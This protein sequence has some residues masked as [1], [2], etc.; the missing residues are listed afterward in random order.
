MT[1]LRAELFHYKGL[2]EACKCANY[3]QERA[4]LLDSLASLR[5]AHGLQRTALDDA[6]A[7]LSFARAELAAARAEG[8]AAQREAAASASAAQAM[9]RRT[10]E[11]SRAAA[12]AK[13]EEGDDVETWRAEAARLRDR[14][15][16]VEAGAEASVTQCAALAAEKVRAAERRAEAAAAQLLLANA[17]AVEVA[18]VGAE[19]A[20]ERRQGEARAT[21]AAQEL[22]EAVRGVQEQ[23]AAELERRLA[24]AAAAFAEREA[25]LRVMHA[26][27]L[28]LAR[29]T[30]RAAAAAAEA[31]GGLSGGS[32]AFQPVALFRP[33]QHPRGLDAAEGDAAPLAPIIELV[34][35]KAQLRP[36]PLPVAPVPGAAE[37]PAGWAQLRPAQPRPAAPEASADE[38]PI[39]PSRPLISSLKSQLRSAPPREQEA[40]EPG[41]I[42]PSRAPIA[43]LKAQLRPAPPR[44]EPVE[45][46]A[47]P[48]APAA[49]VALRPAPPRSSS[50][51][52]ARAP[53]PLEQALQQRQA[54]RA[55]AAE[56]AAAAAAAAA[57]AATVTATAAAAT[58]AQPQRSSTPASAS[59]Q[60]PEESTTPPLPEDEDG[61]EGGSGGGGGGGAPAPPQT[62]ASFCEALRAAGLRSSQLAVFVDCTKSNITN[63]QVSFGGK[64]LHDTSDPSVPNPYQEVISFVV[65]ALAPFD[66]DGDVPVFGFGDQT[67]GD[68]KV[69]AFPP[70]RAGAGPLRAYTDGIATTKLAGPTCFAP[71]IR[72]AVDLY[73]AAKK[74][75]VLICVIIADG[76][77]TQPKETDKAVVEAN[78]YPISIVTVGVGDGP[79]ANME[80]M[81]HNINGQKWDSFRCAHCPPPPSHTHTVHP[82][83]NSSP[84]SHNV[85]VQ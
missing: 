36:P 76:Q 44:P 75:E 33:L 34:T 10:L 25:Q 32:S 81:C 68:K 13:E 69:F 72:R 71:A 18:T 16:S 61:A 82:R 39:A 23:H 47:P 24:D 57:V 79:W 48:R 26:E 12:A 22:A 1:S 40:E 56:E 41:A 8:A 15:R 21:R 66:A 67:T 20:E 6:Q 62:L 64:S 54:A 53:L 2:L 65:D 45:P 19:L 46:V 7:Q 42:A 59:P 70:S 73:K 31:P 50:V 5:A 58:A 49:S 3:T 83:A 35:A 38:A 14:L 37:P 43:S 27:E 63:G 60:L 28:A 11:L 51:V 78:K 17:Q 84:S 55:A 52:Q 30:G 77:V 9:H 29:G 80:R 4:A 74:K 85:Q